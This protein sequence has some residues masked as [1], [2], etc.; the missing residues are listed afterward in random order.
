MKDKGKEWVNMIK[1]E[2]GN[3]VYTGTQQVHSWSSGI[4]SLNRGLGSGWAAGRM[5]LLV[6]KESTGKSTLTSK[7]AAQVNST[8]RKTGLAAHPLHAE[9]CNVLYLDAEGTLDIDWCEHHGYHPNSNGNIVMSTDTGDQLIDVTTS[10]IQ[11]SN[12]S[13]II[14]DS[15]EALVPG[16]DLEKASEDTLV[17]TKAKM[18]NKAYRVWQVAMNEASRNAESWYVRPTLIVINQLRDAI[19]GFMPMPPTIPGGIGQRQFSTSIVQMNSPKYSEDGKE[20]T[21]GTFKGVVKK[22]KVGTPRM[23]FE[24][25]MGLSGLGDLAIGEVDNIR[26]ILKDVRSRG[27]WTPSE[28]G[29]GWSLFGETLPKQ[30]DF[31]MKMRSEPDYELEVMRSTIEA[32]TKGAD[33]G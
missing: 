3:S 9:T 24:F 4:Y 32:I 28:A 16:K 1:K 10:A 15:T 33:R 27:L 7:A 20:P 23:G 22:N 12:F 25:E 14:V 13:M 31:E 5:H 8:S 6:G 29:K 11:S 17:G 26:G 18:M 2:L 30:S 21:K 19:G